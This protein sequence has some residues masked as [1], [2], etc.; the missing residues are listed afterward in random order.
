MKWALNTAKLNL[1]SG[2]FFA[3]KDNGTDYYQYVLL[4]TDKILEIM[5]NPEDFI[6]DE[7][8]KNFVVKPNSIGPPTQYLV[9][10]V[11]YV[12]IENCRS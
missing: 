8:G 6:I 12:T 9:N 11:S 10:K 2:F 1:T 5:K 4:Y 7:L 3:M